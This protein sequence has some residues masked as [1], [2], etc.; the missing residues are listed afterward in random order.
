MQQSLY[1]HGCEMNIKI[2]EYN[3]LEELSIQTNE[4][5]QLDMH[6]NQKHIILKAC[7]FSE[8]SSKLGELC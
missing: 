8:A 2:K 4:Q 6:F 5:R 3:S 7:R 1:E